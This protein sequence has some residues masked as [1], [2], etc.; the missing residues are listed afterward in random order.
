M[1]G[2]GHMEKH[3]KIYVAG[4]AGMVGSALLRKLKDAGF[5]KILVRSRQEL[6]LL[7]QAAVRTFFEQERPEYVFFAAGKTGGIYA[8]NTYRADFIYENIVMQSN[9]IHQ[10]FL[11]ET[12]KLMFYACSCI[13]PKLCP[14]PMSED[15]ILTAA[16][17]PPMSPL[18]WPKS[19]A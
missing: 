7:D 10:A 3:A 14:Q 18:L 17:N 1:N 8:N 16:L 9:V 19:P 4:H 13:Y 6:D 5:S 12:C 11:N 2:S 15:H